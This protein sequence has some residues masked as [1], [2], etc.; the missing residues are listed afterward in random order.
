MKIA[1]AKSL[2]EPVGI[3]WWDIVPYENKTVVAI[4]SALAEHI[5]Y[6][7]QFNYIP[8]TNPTVSPKSIEESLRSVAQRA[9]GRFPVTMYIAGREKCLYTV[10]YQIKRK[11]Y[12]YSIILPGTQAEER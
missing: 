1:I 3:P 10:H 7:K 9:G 6:R 8:Y 4:V 11:C 5:R 2:M 12:K